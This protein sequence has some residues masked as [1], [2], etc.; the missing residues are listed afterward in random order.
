MLSSNPRARPDANFRVQLSG[1]DWGMKCAI[2]VVGAKWG[3]LRSAI[4]S[5]IVVSSVAHLGKADTQSIRAGDIIC[6]VTPTG[7][8]T[9][10][11]H[12]SRTG[13]ISS[14]MGAALMRGGDCIVDVQR[15]LDKACRK[16]KRGTRIEDGDY[17][18]YCTRCGVVLQHAC[19]VDALVG[20]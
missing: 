15:P 8:Q 16:C 13:F 19:W 4:R 1:E 11:N 12:S 5:P 2:D 17:G 14:A 3:G 18:A 10:R 20:R 7:Q 9:L 6:A